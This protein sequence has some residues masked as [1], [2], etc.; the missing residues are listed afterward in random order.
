MPFEP[1]WLEAKQF[2]IVPICHNRLE[3]A[4]EVR[5]AFAALRPDRVAVELPPYLAPHFE[6]AVLR[7]P[8]QTLISYQAT[9]LSAEQLLD[10]LKLDVDASTAREFAD[11]MVRQMGAITALLQ[12]HPADPLV[13]A[14]RSALDAGIPWQAIDLPL[15]YEGQ[16]QDGVPDSSSLTAI[17][18]RAFF[19]QWKQHGSPEPDAQDRDREAHM[20]WKLEALARQHPGQKVLVVVGLA[21]AEP[22][23]RHLLQGDPPMPSVGE[24]QPGPVTLRQPDAQVVETLSPE[25]PFLDTVYEIY[26]GG[27]G[28]RNAWLSPPQEEP[29]PE[30]DDPRNQLKKMDPGQLLSSLES[31]LGMRRPPRPR[32]LTPQQKRALARYLQGLE[33]QPSALFQLLNQF[34]HSG[35]APTAIE[36]PKVPAPPPARAFTFRQVDDRR[37]ELLKLYERALEDSQGLDR[38]RLLSSLLHNSTNFYHENTGDHVAAWQ[39]ETLY[40]YIRNYARLMGRLLPNLYELSMGARGVAD[41]NWA[42]EVWD[43]GSF[44]PWIPGEG[45]EGGC[46][47]ADPLPMVHLEELEGLR[48]RH[49]RWN[50]KLKRL[51]RRAKETRPG[52]WADE[53][54]PHGIC[55]YPPEDVVIEDYAR[56]VQKKAINNMSAEK[57]RIEPFTTSL[58]DGIDMRETLR[59]W[60]ERKLFVKDIRRVQGGVGAVIL[61]FD[62]DRQ[63]SR[64]PWCMTWHGEHSQE[65]DMA[66]YATNAQMKLVGPGISRCEYGGLLMTYPNRQLPNIWADDFYRRDCRTKAEYLL[67]G[68]I[69]YGQDRHIVYVAAE[70]PRSHFGTLAGRLGKRLIY[71]PIGSLSPD[72][73]KRIRV[74]HVLS[75]HDK[76]R[77]AKDFIW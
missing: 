57:T 62:E 55:S 53:F 71:L 9:A 47:A 3:F 61:I 69:E 8:F 49:W 64:Y 48:L 46:C 32:Q 18:A 75:G 23:R 59:N 1:F 29:D 54:E 42:Y 58:L 72:S 34:A 56:Y 15:F 5:R 16:H 66:F 36:L 77:I 73:I 33:E 24:Y 35:P 70:P 21:H 2:Y 63:D 40:Q 13:E 31:M 28:P 11:E 14:V 20:A 50:R 12:I 30:D 25:I 7:L 52:E 6:R 37:G 27:P 19:E 4:L 38:Q 39:L 60:H 51:R 67:M 74:F 17:G 45:G 22:L 10:E 41:D 44:Y 76:R 65:S 26:R 43:L 68:A